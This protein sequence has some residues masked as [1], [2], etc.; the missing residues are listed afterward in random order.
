MSSGIPLWVLAQESRIGIEHKAGGL[1]VVG[2][3]RK[4]PN[5]NVCKVIK[6]SC[7]A[8][9]CVERNDI[10]PAGHFEITRKQQK[11]N[12]QSWES[13]PTCLNCLI[14]RIFVWPI[15]SKQ[16]SN[17]R[18]S[19]NRQSSLVCRSFLHRIALGSNNKLQEIYVYIYMEIHLYMRSWH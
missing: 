7:E 14:R 18:R 15:L 1:C 4:K 6:V 3:D 11:Q 5:R 13:V 19:R 9:R 16:T 8:H 17:S 12:S 10:K 2:E